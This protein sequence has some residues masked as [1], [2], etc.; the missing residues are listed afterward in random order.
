MFK[1]V[2]LCYDGSKAG[3]AALKQGAE[4]AIL[5]G[6]EVHVLSIIS[7]EV[8][9]P[10]VLAGAARAQI[11][12]HRSQRGLAEAAQ[13][14][15]AQRQPFGGTRDPPLPAQLPF[16]FLKP[17]YLIGGVPAQ[18]ACHRVDVDVVQ[19]GAGMFLPELIDQIVQLADLLQS[20]GSLAVAEW[21]IAA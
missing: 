17:A 7:S 5:V 13:R 21:F 15:R 2:L 9:D 14:L 3:R 8:P 19:R 16:Q 4:L 18:V 11:C 6:A 1:H 10:V 12:E 20:A